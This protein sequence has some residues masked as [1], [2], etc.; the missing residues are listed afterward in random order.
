MRFTWSMKW[1][2]ALK[3]PVVS[4]DSSFP[5][6]LPHLTRDLLVLR[7]ISRTLDVRRRQKYSLSFRLIDRLS[8][9]SYEDSLSYFSVIIYTNNCNFFEINYS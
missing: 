8:S 5:L 4:A 1:Q 6:S 2:S 7:I 3:R 9:E